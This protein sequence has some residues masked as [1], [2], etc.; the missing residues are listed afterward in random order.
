M[1]HIAII[2]GG[3][4]GLA[5]A[6]YLEREAQARGQ[7]VRCTLLESGP[8]LGG[9]IVTDRQNEFTI[10]GG[11][12][13]FIVDKPWCLQLCHDV[14]LGDDLI[15]SNEIQR[16]VYVLRHGRLVPFPTGFRLTVPSELKPFLL[17]PLI[18]PWGKLRMLGDLVIPPRRETADESL[19]SFI[20]R[21]LG[22]EA[23]DRIAGPLLAGIFVSDPERLSM[24][25]TFPRLQAME[26]EYG[27]LIRAARA[28]RALP[29][30][31][32]QPR[33]A[34]NAMFN[35]LKHGMGSLVDALARDVKADVRLGTRVAMLRREYGRH[36]LFLGQTGTEQIQADAV[37][38]TAPA[39]QAAAL[40]RDAYPTLSA[41]LA[42]IRFV[43]TTTV[44]LAY[45]FDDIPAER[46]LDGFGVL[47]PESEKRRL[48]AVTWASTKFRHRAPSGCVLMRAFVGGYRDEALA[49]LPEEALVTMIRREFESLFGIA[50]APMFHRIYRWPRANPQYDVGHLQRVAAIEK[51]A[52]AWPGL[53]LAGGS[54]RG[55]GMPDCINSARRAVERVLA[56]P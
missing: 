7:E 5:A 49:S 12:D 38:V 35:S 25:S 28:V 9:K 44:S 19:A 53:E 43:D 46:P 3:I 18:S 51:E 21:R 32:T 55:V 24:E 2:G 11:P 10:E 42:E 30:P 45:L 22:A 48:I 15:P 54:Y 20:R 33:S 23:L 17:S 50:N 29:A 4:T 14:G 16:K 31:A 52:S 47:V 6:F 37:I 36:T 26:R 41:K 34:G 40:L 56:L 27:S 8:R 39:H 1:K 13:S